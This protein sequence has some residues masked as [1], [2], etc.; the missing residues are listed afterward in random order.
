MKKI[1][2]R[3]DD[4][5]PWMDGKKW[6]RMF[7]ILDRYEVKPL[8]GIIPHNLDPQTRIEDEDASFW[9]KMV[10]LA[11]RGYSIALHGFDHKCATDCGGVNPVHRRSEFAG[12]P[13][14]VQREKIHEGIEIFKSHGLIPKYFFAPSH[15]FDDNTLVA[16]EEESEIRLICDTFKLYPY[17]WGNFTVIPQQMGSF[18]NPPLPG[19]WVFCFHPN[20]MSDSEFDG[21]EA[22]IRSNRN[23]FHDFNEFDEC[24]ASVSPLKKFINYICFKSY[25][26][27][28]KLR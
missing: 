21:F 7:S 2:V 3:L 19:H 10:Q 1:Y 22:F 28:R 15:T 6:D 16:L 27:L 12:L 14:Y 26:L 8:I 25:L 11:S 23:S 17:K 4:A 9:E 20:N 5:S 24:E 18:R 13:L